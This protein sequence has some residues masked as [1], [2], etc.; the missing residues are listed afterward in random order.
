MN[1]F[2]NMIKVA[3]LAVVSVFVFAAC[4]DD[5]SNITAAGVAD[6]SEDV[7]IGIA[8]WGSQLR[9]D[10]TSEVI[11]MFMDLHPNITVEYEF[12]DSSGYWTALDTRVA[13]NDVWDLFQLGS[14]YPEYRDHILPL[15]TFINSG[16]I[17]T[18]N[19]TQEF[20]DITTS[21]GGYIVGLS[22]GVNAQGIAY[23]P[24]MFVAAGVPLPHINWTWAE[25]E[26]AALEIAASQGHWGFGNWGQNEGILLTQFIRQQGYEL[27]H[28]TDDRALGIDNPSTMVEYFRMRQTMVEAGASPNVGQMM[29]ITDI[30]GDPVAMGQAAMTYVASN[31]FVALNNAAQAHD[32]N[33]QLRMTVLPGHPGGYAA[34]NVVN[35]QMFSMSTTDCEGRQ[36]AAAMFLDFFANS[37]DANNILQAERGIP[38]MNHVRDA[39]EANAD[40]AV[41]QTFAFISMVGQ[42]SDED[43]MGHII[44]NPRQ[45]EIED[46]INTQVERVITGL[47]TPEEAAQAL[48]DFALFIVSQN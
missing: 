38:I 12:F 1:R 31:Q 7:T 21:A 37:I 33:R 27:Y 35:S 42:L 10:R 6:G 2:K 46:H 23:D 5:S 3:A 32:P 15:N 4:G 17:D 13:A 29:L 25:F 48:L 30:E 41:A 9:H 43:G 36:Q 45:A 14:N 16:V 24:A 19:T 39:L 20:I 47:A 40:E 26:A 18:S 11:H 8:W 28:E 22:N 34:S 44:G